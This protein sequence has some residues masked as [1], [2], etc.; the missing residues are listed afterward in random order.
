MDREEA[1]KAAEVML[2]YAEG[3][4]IES[5]DTKGKWNICKRPNFNWGGYLDNYRI[6]PEPS[7]RPFKDGEEC[8]QEL[9]LHFPYGWVKNAKTQSNYY[10]LITSVSPKGIEFCGEFYSF[11]LAFDGFKFA[12]GSPFGIRIKEDEDDQREEDEDDGEEDDWEEDDGE[13]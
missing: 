10:H 5:M 11:S 9:L 12:D 7:Y 3:K 13:E 6:K 1:R 4:E 2:A 8:W